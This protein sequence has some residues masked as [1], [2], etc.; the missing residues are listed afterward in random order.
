VLFSS[1]SFTWE[2]GMRDRNPGGS[3]INSGE[4][5]NFQLG[6]CIDRLACTT[7]HDPHG[8][9]DPARTSFIE[10]P[11]GNSLC[12]DCHPAY[13]KP[14]ALVAHTH[15]AADSAGSV[16][17]NCHMPRKNMALDYGLS[18]YHRIASPTDQNKVLKD[19]P[20]ECALC[21]PGS[22][23]EQ[24]T[25]TME[26]WWGKHYDRRELKAL[27]SDLDQ[28]VVVATLEQGKPHEQAVALSLLDARL[29]PEALELATQ[30]FTN[31]YPL[32]RYYARGAIERSSGKPLDVDMSLPGKELQARVEQS[33]AKGSDSEAHRSASPTTT[34]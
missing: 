1:Y 19:R 16:C 18:R 13:E 10:S 24:L 32:V 34:P 5:R 17:V 26:Q 33:L 21:H 29:H 25:S 12:Q 30:E 14:K 27:Y 4:A 3:S 22:T 31:R 28:N 8:R 9:D 20:L 11:A 2:G 6:G 15:H 7:C 23:V